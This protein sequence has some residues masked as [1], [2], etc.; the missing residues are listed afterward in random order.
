MMNRGNRN[1]MGSKRKFVSKLVEK[2]AI[3]EAKRIL[4]TS[5]DP[6]IMSPNVERY[7]LDA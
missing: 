5:I 1:R 7:K 2:P 4:T 6:T 3:N